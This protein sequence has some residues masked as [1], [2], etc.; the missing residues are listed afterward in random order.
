MLIKLINRCLP[1][2]YRNNRGTWGAI[3]GAVI[4]AGGAAINSSMN[5]P[6]EMGYDLPMLTNAP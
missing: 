2:K 5:K 3:A 6:G 4:G 1:K